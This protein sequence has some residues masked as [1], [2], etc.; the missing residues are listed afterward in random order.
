MLVASTLPWLVLWSLTTV[1]V[2]GAAANAAPDA[3]SVRTIKAV[4]IL[5]SA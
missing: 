3:T 4:A 5:F 2:L 1:P